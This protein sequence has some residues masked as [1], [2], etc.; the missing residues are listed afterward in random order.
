MDRPLRTLRAL[1]FAAT[2]SAAG[3]A[4]AQPQTPPPGEAPASAMVDEKGEVPNA[5]KVVDTFETS[6]D[7]EP[8][9]YRHLWIAYSAIWLLVFGFMFR[10]YKKSEATQAELELLKRRLAD[11]EGKNGD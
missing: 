4:L 3:L 9:R 2:L 5:G 6:P 1:A 11:L 7:L 8:M 10:T